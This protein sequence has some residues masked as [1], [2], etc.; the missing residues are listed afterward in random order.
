ML[1]EVLEVV[2]TKEKWCPKLRKFQVNEFVR[3]VRYLDRPSAIGSRILRHL[4]PLEAL[5]PS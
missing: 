4:E 5:D 1:A 2:C 3:A